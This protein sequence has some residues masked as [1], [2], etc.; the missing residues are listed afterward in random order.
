[1]APRQ[2]YFSRRSIHSM[3]PPRGTGLRVSVIGHSA[4]QLGG[5]G[6][7]FS[8]AEARVIL[9]VQEVAGSNAATAQ[10]F[11]GL[12]CIHKEPGSIREPEW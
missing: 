4:W 12:T 7:N 9:G 11:E 1:M 3:G 5:D 6:H 2:R 10:I 8:Q